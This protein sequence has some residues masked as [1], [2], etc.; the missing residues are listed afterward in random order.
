MLEQKETRRKF[1]NQGNDQNYLSWWQAAIAVEESMVND[2]NNYLQ[3]KCVEA[4]EAATRN[5]SSKLFS[6]IRDITG[7]STTN[8]ATNVSKKKQKKPEVLQQI[9]MSL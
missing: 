1:R 3:R 4:E 7:K 2:R 9:E 8:S 6:V 5:Q